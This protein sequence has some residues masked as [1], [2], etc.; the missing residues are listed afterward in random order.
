MKKAFWLSLMVAGIIASLALTGPP[1]APDAVDR[2]VSFCK[3]R[4]VQFKTTA[5][6]LQ[7]TVQDIKEGDSVSVA[8]ARQAL[9]ECRLAYKS[10]SFFLSYFFTSETALY[11]MPARYEIE[12]PYM[13]Y[14]EPSGLQVI[15]S[16]L[17]EPEPASHR[18]ALLAQ[19]DLILSSAS[20]LSSLFF[21][22]N[23][24]SSQLLESLRLEFVR[25][26]TLYISG[27][28]APLLKTG[29]VESKEA[30][31]AIQYNLQPF[32]QMRS[33]LADSLA[34]CMQ[35]A[36]SYLETN[37]AFDSFNRLAF[38]TTYGLPLQ[39]QLGKLIREAGLEL[40]TGGILNYG[41]S[42]LFSP[43]ILQV[44]AFSGEGFVSNEAL[45][46]LGRRLFF[47]KVLSGN[48]IR[49]CAGCHR[50]DQYFANSLVRDTAFDGHS[51]L[52]RNTPGLL[53]AAYQHSQF[54]DGRAGTLEDQIRTVLR[55]PVEMNVTEDSMINRLLR[56]GYSNYFRPAFPQAAKDSLVSMKHT[57]AALAA[58]IRSLPVMKSDFDRYF[59]GDTTAL[60]TQQQ[61]GANLF[62][63]KA[64]CATC[65]F[66]PLFNGLTPP[67]YELTEFEV[68][69]TT[70]TDSLDKPKADN[71]PGRFGFFPVSFYRQAFKTPTVRNA[72]VTG[73]YMH[74]GKFSSMEKLIDFYDKGGAAG[75]G[76][77][78]ENQTLSATP[79]YL[80][81]E[82]KK[83]LIAFI[84]ALTDK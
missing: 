63:G 50:P 17:Y 75:L 19:A 16:L 28:D 46:E 27:F 45:V 78:I 37:K 26:L 61:W 72:A 5:A 59:N 77:Q 32:L 33:P 11:N 55:S 52:P 53:Y 81:V 30:L 38:L 79:L 43:D 68:L 57:A 66:A 80:T 40:N 23:A 36:I 31:L 14:Q 71:D 82:E 35:H 4:T 1:S 29:I 34:L 60:S 84:E 18:E 49:S 51:L 6:R 7:Q 12:E 39:I 21:Q 65:H 25:I 3:E 20:D 69:G 22:F 24:E 9:A 74:N 47:E 83:A 54:W 76:I 56:L 70:L 44:N 10:I 67:L 41:A 8:A 62:M 64:Q 15:E 2:T 58:F 73:P 13:E 48:Q 42:H